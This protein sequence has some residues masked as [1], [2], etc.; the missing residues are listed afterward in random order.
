MNAQ[1]IMDGPASMD[2]RRREK[3]LAAIALGFTLI[4]P[5]MTLEM[6]R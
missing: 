3:M 6:P 5:L 2:A 4:A 1:G